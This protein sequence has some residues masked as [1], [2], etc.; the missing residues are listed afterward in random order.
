MFNIINIERLIEIDRQNSIL[1]SK[2]QN[3]KDTKPAED[4]LRPESQWLKT[5]NIHFNNTIKERVNI[6]N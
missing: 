5:L 2:M 4:K 6:E 3:L 1:L